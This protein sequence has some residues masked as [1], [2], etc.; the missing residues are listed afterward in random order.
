MS[1]SVGQTGDEVTKK[2]TLVTAEKNEKNI[3]EAAIPMKL[4]VSYNVFDGEELLEYS[5]RSIRESVDYVSV[6]YQTVS[7]YGA[8]CTEDLVET[9]IRLKTNGLIDELYEYMPQMLSRDK[10]NASYNEV[11]KRNIGLNMSRKNNCTHHMSMDCDEF[12]VPEQFIY[13]K[14]VIDENGYESAACQ[15]QNY[16]KDSIYLLNDSYADNY[17]STIYKINGDTKFVYRSKDSP[18]RMDPTRRT[19]NKNYRI[20]VR[21][22]IRMHHMTLVRR[23]LRRKFM[24]S[25]YR[26]HGFGYRDTLI[27]RVNRKHGF[28]NIDA[29]VDYYNNWQYPKPAM[30]AQGTLIDVIKVDRLFKLPLQG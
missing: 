28:G 19:N 11:E 26:K 30:S 9:L 21:S 29:I 20:F 8:A 3:I 5:I 17:V 16:Y 14:K 2:A 15:Y 6:V 12:Y 1:R 18:V 10:N 27:G 25:S 23:D 4:G 13:M 22:E 7:N 24:N